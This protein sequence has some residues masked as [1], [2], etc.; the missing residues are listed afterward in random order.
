MIGVDF[1]HDSQK[2]P[3]LLFSVDA[4]GKESIDLYQTLVV[5]QW[6]VIGVD[7]FSSAKQHLREF[8]FNVAVVLVTQSFTPELLS[9]L[10]NLFG[11]YGD[12]NWLLVMPEQFETDISMVSEVETLISQ[13][14]FD[15]HHTPVRDELFL[16]VLGHAYGMA[17]I[18]RHPH[19]INSNDYAKYG[20]IGTSE[21]MQVLFNQIKKVCMLDTPV[22][23]S[24]ETGTG[25]ELVA[26]AIH[27]NS[28]RSEKKLIVINCASLTD[29][30]IQ[31][32]LFGYEKGAFTGAY[33]RKIGLI[34][35][36]DGGTLFLD[37]IGDLPLEQQ[38]NL[39]RF[40]QEKTIIRVGGHEE[41]PVDI[42]IIAAT[43]VDLKAAVAK[44]QFR[45]DLYYRLNVLHLKVPP[46][47]ERGEDVDLLCQYFLQNDGAMSNSKQKNLCA[48]ALQVIRNYEW[49][50]NV[51]ELKNTL[52][53]AQ[54]MSDNHII[55]P[56]DL[57]LERRHH[58][59]AANTLEKSRA[60]ADL[61]AIK[62]SLRQSKN[63]I[64]EAASLLG[65][66]RVTLYRLLNKYQLTID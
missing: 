46:L 55:T 31:A 64:S 15:F 42:R 37:E 17:E 8:P 2:R 66:S 43:N 26:N 65:I 13:F 56:A 5:N 38:A 29:S 35:A 10:Q 47:R 51:R 14:C 62:S 34:E 60:D 16:A 50:G 24:G 63:N 19:K 1:M 59:Y 32:E 44:G 39:L 54:I 22:L 7:S 20:I 30:I 27:Y 58:R 18:A 41:I 57:D 48:Q 45:D 36:S 40:L 9:Q 12:T 3:V 21:P 6:K 4:I 52:H 25:K 49:K 11:E 33:K 61:S 28:A 53:R 23:I